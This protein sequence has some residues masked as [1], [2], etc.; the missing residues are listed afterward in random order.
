MPSPDGPVEIQALSLGQAVEVA[1]TVHGTVHSVFGR[2]VN[3]SIGGGLWTL[4]A[5]SLADMP[6][7]VRLPLRDFSACDLRIGQ[8]VHVRS[9][10]LGIGSGRC[11][12]LV[13][14]C[15]SATRWAPTG[16]SVIAPGLSGRLALVE[17][18]VRRRAWSGAGLL[19]QTVVG[20]LTERRRLA[21]VIA[22]VIGRGPGLTPAGDDVII[23]ILAV[24]STPAAGPVG[25]T[26]ADNLRQAIGPRLTATTAISSHLLH[27]ACEGH[28]SRP[29]HEFTAAL[30]AQSARRHIEDCLARLVTVGATSGADSATGLLAAASFVLLPPVKRVAA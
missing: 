8:A 5:E 27:Q 12:P 16:G 2:A 17:P 1:A 13:I 15:R 19:A 10:Y 3:L 29:L 30:V 6:Y 18:I 25:R 9:S 4:L 22:N 21:G 28:F 7:G 11:L 26:T 20:A 24:L 14:D 23:G